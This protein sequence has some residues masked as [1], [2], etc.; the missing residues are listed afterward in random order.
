VKRLSKQ[1]KEDQQRAALLRRVTDVYSGA[2]GAIWS[3]D[4]FATAEILSRVI[5]ALRELFAKHWKDYMS[6]AH[7]LNHFDNAE[8]AAAWLFEQG[9][10]A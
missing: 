2:M 7:A 3:V 9:V 5:P 4:D 6:N 8:S 10:R 1:Q